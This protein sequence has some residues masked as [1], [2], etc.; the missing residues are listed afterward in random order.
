[1]RRVNQ[2]LAG[3][4]KKV[5]RRD[6]VSLIGKSA[7]QLYRLG[8]AVA[9]GL[10]SPCVA[11]AQPPALQPARD[12][13]APVRRELEARYA[14]NEAG[15]FARDADR[16]MRLRHPGFHTVTPDGRVSNREQM[17]ERTRS[18]IGRIERF[19]SLSESIVALTLAGDTAHA[20]VLQRT[21]RQQRFPDGVLHE[22]RTW[23]VQRESWI[24]AADGWL[25]WRVDQVQPGWTLDNGTLV[26]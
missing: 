8:L 20:V 26:R 25:F 4:V 23:A 5:H 9:F 6:D 12:S 14:E 15:F 22:I 21:V 10:A 11:Y 13:L 2:F 17:Y 24:K 16:V 7:M 3:C 19:D 18:F 1:M